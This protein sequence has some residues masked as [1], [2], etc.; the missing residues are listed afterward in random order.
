M[1]AELVE[2][3]ARLTAVDREL[4]ALGVR[5]ELAMSAF[6]FDEAREVQQR[7]ARLERERADLAAALPATAPS[8]AAAPVPVGIRPRRL[9]RRRR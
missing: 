9:V 1:M 7:I 8:T 2:K 5:H 6:K 4:A 3:G